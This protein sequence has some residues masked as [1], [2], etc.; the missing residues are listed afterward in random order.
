MPRLNDIK[1]TKFK[2]KNYRPWD[3]DSNLNLTSELETATHKQSIQEIETSL[4]RNWF[5]HDRPENELGDIESLAKEF[6]DIGQ[7]QPCIVR[8]LLNDN[9]Y[10]YELIVGERR[11][12][13]ATLAELPL[14]V[15]V[16]PMSDNDAAII[17]ISENYNRKGL[18]DYARGISYTRLIE[19][20]MITQ[21]D[22]TEKL[23]MSRQR[24]SRLLSFSKI[25]PEIVQVIGNMSKVS[26]STAEVIKQLSEKGPSYIEAII[27]YASQ[28]RKGEI[29]H[30][31]L[32]ELVNNYINKTSS[33]VVHH[34]KIHSSNK[35]Q[36]LFT[37]EYDATKHCVLSFPK[38]VVDLINSKNSNIELVIGSLRKTLE[39]IVDT[40]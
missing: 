22:L 11:W 25:S 18:S 14:K 16:K 12:R 33:H 8:P 27:T 40:S 28:I 9:Q 31:K 24:I 3:T 38:Q 29:G 17:Q 19:Q 32:S 35:G 2:K 7:Q 10:K 15:I 23:G 20:G 30:R 37:L 13:A 6:Q 4:I 1:E 34:K 26:Y 21:K 36:Y 5:Y 39:E